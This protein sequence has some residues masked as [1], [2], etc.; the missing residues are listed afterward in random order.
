M[1]NVQ[2]LIVVLL[3]GTS[4]VLAKILLNFL[5]P[6][7]ILAGRLIMALIV[8]RTIMHHKNI[9]SNINRKDRPFILLASFILSLHFLLQITGLNFT[10]ATNT[11][12]LIVVA[13]VF[14]AIAS[15]L[16]LKEKLKFVQ[17]GGIVIATIGVILLISEGKLNSLDWISSIG[18]WMILVSGIT[19]TV[20]TLST[21]NLS[22]RM[23]PLG[24]IY[25]ILFLPTIGF[26]IYVVLTSSVSKFL[27]LPLQPIIA[28]LIYGFLSMGIAHWLW[29]EGVSKKG[30]A[31][32]G[33][34]IY[35]EPL[36]TTIAAIF[37]LNER[38]D[39]WGYL[40]GLVIVLGVYLVEKK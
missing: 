23:E 32:A 3:W 24:L 17:I 30:A 35:L 16:F 14:I 37:L 15:Y 31:R 33:T 40:G 29:L 7:E 6:A 8:L 36:V 39:L 18:D 10:S 38:L 20:Y 25:K 12:W 2:L 19:W 34:F 11:G 27:S 13:P 21:R 4:F 28:F 1:A 26:I 9:K 22:R 5:N